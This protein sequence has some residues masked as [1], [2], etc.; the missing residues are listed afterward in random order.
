[1]IPLH[2]VFRIDTVDFAQVVT[3]ELTLMSSTSAL[4]AGCM[5]PSSYKMG[6]TERVYYALQPLCEVP[7]ANFTLNF[8]LG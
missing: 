3:S 7:D 8:A 1:V 6:P 2:S 4:V 5:D